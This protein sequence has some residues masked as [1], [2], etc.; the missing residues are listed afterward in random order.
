MQADKSS[1]TPFLLCIVIFQPIF[2]A[3]VPPRSGSHGLGGVADGTCQGQEGAEA[4]GRFG[5]SAALIQR[6]SYT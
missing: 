6:R 3:S 1:K 2:A 5:R 4:G